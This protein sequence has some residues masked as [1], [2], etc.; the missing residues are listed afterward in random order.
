MTQEEFRSMTYEEMT[1]FLLTTEDVDA[2]LALQQHLV[3]DW[4]ERMAAT[5]AHAIAV[6]D[7]ALMQTMA[8]AGY[9][10]LFDLFSGE[11]ES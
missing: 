5:A 10:D 3:R 11:G 6:G 9:I 7:V 2:C 4:R 8:E 1:E